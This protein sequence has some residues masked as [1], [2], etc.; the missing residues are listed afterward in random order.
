MEV[1]AVYIVAACDDPLL[2]SQSVIL[3]YTTA[4]TFGHL[5]G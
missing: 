5:L 1:V 2:N 3:D 4:T